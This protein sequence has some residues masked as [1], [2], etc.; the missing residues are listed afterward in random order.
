MSQKSYWMINVTTIKKI[1]LPTDKELTDH[2][3]FLKK[4]KKNYF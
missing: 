2:S 1:I 3:E 4:F